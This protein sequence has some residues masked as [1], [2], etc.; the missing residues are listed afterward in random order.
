M[1]WLS[2]SEYARLAKQTVDWTMDQLVELTVIIT[3]TTAWGDVQSAINHIE[4]VA[5]L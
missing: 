3:N 5:Q 1:M 2:E 4:K